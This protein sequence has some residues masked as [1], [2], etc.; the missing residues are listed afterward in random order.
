MVAAAWRSDSPWRSEVVTG[1]RDDGPPPHAPQAEQAVLGSLILRPAGLAAAGL[2]PADF[3]VERNRVVFEAVG[4]LAG[5][6]TPIDPV[7]LAEE[8]QRSGRLDE[9]GG[10]VY[11]AD[12]MAAVPHAEHLGHYAAQVRE[13]AARRGSLD[14]LNE[15][16]RLLRDGS[17]LD[18]AV[19]EIDA[20]RSALGTSSASGAVVRAL[21]DVPAEH[22]AWLWPGRVPLGK[23]T[24]LAGDPGLGKSF[25]TLDLAARVSSGRGWPD[26]SSGAWVSGGLVS[27]EETDSDIEDQTPGT[28]RPDTS[29][30]RGGDVI[31][32]GAE[33][34]LADTVRPRLEAAGADLARVVAVEG[35]RT[36]GGPRG[37][38]L[39]ADLPRLDAILAMRPESRLVVIDPITAYCGGVDTHK[40][41][42][43]RALLAPLSELAARRRVA[44]VAVTHL[45]KAAGGKAIYRAMG[46]LAY[47]AAARV[48]WVVAKDAAD[49]SRRLLLPVKNNLAADAGGLAYRIE[50][51]PDGAAV[52][53]WEA[54]TV[55]M[56]ADEALEAGR[57]TGDGE[58]GG[59]GDGETVRRRNRAD[60]FLEERLAEGP[61]PTS[62]VLE[63]A[64]GAGISYKMLRDAKRRLG[65]RSERQADGWC[66]KLDPD[67]RPG[68]DLAGAADLFDDPF[69]GR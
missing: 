10:I 63:D 37:F 28:S 8:L 45:N 68:R 36:S 9:A 20:A 49:P 4:R 35:V 65:V 48:G 58:K 51:R 56:D 46:S 59:G 2:G 62:K 69:A 38:S 30:P 1:G 14:R 41:A 19:A 16:A 66:L 33:D 43:V 12:L 32:F 15:A 23:L 13:S 7:T 54:G 17:E 25:V 11:L 5:A 29:P 60:E 39:S 31:L 67:R 24:L 27:G 18:L 57:R 53:A 22:L 52:V 42:D 44:V 26:E 47:V 64:V 40:N 61:V 55:E 34:D 3:Y 6:G 50:N 21:S